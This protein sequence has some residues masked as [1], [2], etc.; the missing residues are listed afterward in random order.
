[1]SYIFTTD[2]IALEVGK[3]F[4]VALLVTS[5]D[6]VDGD[7]YQ[8]SVDPPTAPIQFGRH[9]DV[10]HCPAGGLGRVSFESSDGFAAAGSY[11]FLVRKTSDPLTVVASRDV[12]VAVSTPTPTL[13]PGP[14]GPQGPQGDPGP[15]GPQGDTGP[16]GP[17]G[18]QGDP[19]P[20]GPQG[21]A[22][23]QGQAG[24]A[25]TAP[26]T[27]AV[28]APPVP[29]VQKSSAAELFGKAIDFMTSGMAAIIV[30]VMV[31]VIVLVL[32]M[33]AIAVWLIAKNGESQHGKPA[34]AI[35]Q[36]APPLSITQTN[37]PLCTS[38]CTATDNAVG[39]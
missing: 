14:T 10:L 9:T 27:P 13:I 16:A 1:M 30:F 38:N 12:D 24:P 34:A 33:P 15:A 39:Y 29:Q 17:I 20:A 7:E 31:L 37:N 19:G 3:G 22:G 25:G 5:P 23:A 21:P 11:K 18:P 2:P 28:P 4:R 32:F 26:A 36:T 6:A 8:I 35:Q